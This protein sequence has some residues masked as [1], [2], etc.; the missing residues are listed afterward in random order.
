[1]AEVLQLAAE[2]SL[3]VPTRVRTI[4]RELFLELTLHTNKRIMLEIYFSEEAHVC[5]VPLYVPTGTR[6]EVLVI[7]HTVAT[8]YLCSMQYSAPGQICCF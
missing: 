1:L 4:T 6:I 7:V 3:A 2:V 8:F 5:T